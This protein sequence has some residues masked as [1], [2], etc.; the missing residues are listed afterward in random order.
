MRD[1]CAT[2]VRTVGEAFIV[3][4]DLGPPY[5]RTA[6]LFFVFVLCTKARCVCGVGVSGYSDRLDAL[7]VCV[8]LVVRYI[9]SC[10]LI[11]SLRRTGAFFIYF[12]ARKIKFTSG[13]HLEAMFVRSHAI[14]L[15]GTMLDLQ[16]RFL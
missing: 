9:S 14:I 5:I 1:Y 11:G 16:G 10:L 8:R 15:K 3:T 12:F 7:N 6:F 13:A 2:S 4:A